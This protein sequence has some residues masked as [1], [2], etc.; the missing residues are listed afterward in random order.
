MHQPQLLG[1][2]FSIFNHCLWLR[3]TFSQ[4][5]LPSQS[6]LYTPLGSLAPFSLS[7][8][9]PPGDIT[10]YKPLYILRKKGGGVLVTVYHKPRFHLSTWL[11]P[12]SK[13]FHAP[14]LN[15]LCRRMGKYTEI[16]THTK[17]EH[18]NTR[19]HS[20]RFHFCRPWPFSSFLI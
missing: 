4:P 9:N 6:S 7:T 8:T 15:E 14:Q 11:Y 19:T 16:H 13:T 2:I 17:L 5:Y 18:N 10:T 3:N 1:K 12:H 20:V